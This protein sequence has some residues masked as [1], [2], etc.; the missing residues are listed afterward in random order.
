MWWVMHNFKDSV[1][2]VC[3]VCSSNYCWP[4]LDDVGGRKLTT[5]NSAKSPI[6]L[7]MAASP[8]SVSRTTAKYR[9]KAS[10]TVEWDVREAVQHVDSMQRSWTASGIFVLVVRYGSLENNGQKRTEQC[11]KYKQLEFE[12]QRKCQNQF[13][14]E[15]LSSGWQ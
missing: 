1:L 13:S 3:G 11:E 9:Y 8:Y 6:V 10:E 12:S 5:T 4:I 7:Y 15:E 14:P 2:A